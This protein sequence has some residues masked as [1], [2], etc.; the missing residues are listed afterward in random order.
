MRG[1]GSPPRNAA[2]RGGGPP[3]NTPDIPGFNILLWACVAAEVLLATL[4]YEEE[5]GKRR[6]TADW[7][8]PV[9]LAVVILSASFLQWWSEQKAESMMEALQ[10]MQSEEAV[11]GNGGHDVV[12][13]N[14]LL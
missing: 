1:G 9:I 12:G 2:V 10:A 6:S 8:T 3:R 7:V 4:L 11:R 14:G 13:G 5:V